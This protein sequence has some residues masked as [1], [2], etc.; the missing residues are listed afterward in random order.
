MPTDTK[1]VTTTTSGLQ[2]IKG[3]LLMFINALV[4]AFNYIMQKV[5]LKRSADAGN[6]INPYEWMYWISLLLLPI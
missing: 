6:P 5:L 3:I 2:R 4:I 1:D